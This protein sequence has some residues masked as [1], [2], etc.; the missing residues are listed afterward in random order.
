MKKIAVLT[1]DGA[2]ALLSRPDPGGFDSSRVPNPRN[3]SSK[4]KKEL[5]SH[6]HPV[7]KQNFFHFCSDQGYDPRMAFPE[8]IRS[9]KKL[10]CCL[11]K[12]IKR[13]FGKS[14]WLKINFTE[15]MHGF[16]NTVFRKAYI[17]YIKINSNRGSV[18]LCRS[19]QQRNYDYFAL[20]I[21]NKQALLKNDLK[22]KLT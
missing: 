22:T 16:C 7:S 17:S 19:T 5:W 18:W 1:E 14:E 4:A 12:K 11:K 6:A 15:T 10:T 3:L 20:V 21:Y 2:F 9:S 13:H 8:W